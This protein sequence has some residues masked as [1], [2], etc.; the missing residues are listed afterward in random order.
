VII[1]GTSLEV[2]PF[3]SIINECPINVPRILMN[4]NLVGPFRL[5]S[6]YRKRDLTIL[7][8]LTNTI[9]TI[10]SKIGWENELN[11]LCIRELEIIVIYKYHNVYFTLFSNISIK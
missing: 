6:S 11:Q 2:E 7:G 8:D 5:K 9:E 4:K 10:A 1:I 3:A